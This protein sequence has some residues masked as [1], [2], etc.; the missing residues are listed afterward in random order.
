MYPRST[1]PSTTLERYARSRMGADW[2]A[3]DQP[4]TCGARI[5]V[6]TPD[7]SCRDLACVAVL[8]VWLVLWMSRNC[9]LLLAVFGAVE[10]K[11]K[12]VSWMVI[13]LDS[14]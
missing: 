14:I 2:S 10:K 12:C 13:V 11:R 7:D 1:S 8:H 5:A 4:A 3:H 9:T 6:H